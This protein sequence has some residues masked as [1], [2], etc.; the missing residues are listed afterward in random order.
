MCI[1]DTDSEKSYTHNFYEDVNFA[2]SKADENLKT[3]TELSSE[4]E[5]QVP[6]TNDENDP[7]DK[8]VYDEKT[9]TEI[10]CPDKVVVSENIIKDVCIDEGAKAS[11]NETE[12]SGN[13]SSNIAGGGKDIALKTVQDQSQVPDENE[14]V[15]GEISDVKITSLKELFFSEDQKSAGLDPKNFDEKI[16]AVQVCPYQHII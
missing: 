15:I 16:S 12:E 11:P 7:E 6:S 5:L 10:L 9:I 14:V 2:L 13:A 3:D 4:D 8:R 1:P